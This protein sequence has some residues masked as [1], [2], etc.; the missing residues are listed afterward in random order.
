[1]GKTQLILSFVPHL[2][3][4]GDSSK[5]YD[6]H[7]LYVKAASVQDKVYRIRFK[8][9]TAGTAG[10]ATILTETLYVKADNKIDSSPVEIMSPRIACNNKLWCDVA[11]ETGSGTLDLLVGLHTYQG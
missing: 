2:L 11:C 9:A 7:R 6:F 1:M 4:G 3:L 10:T 5:K 8:Y